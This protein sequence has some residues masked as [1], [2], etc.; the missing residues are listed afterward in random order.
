MAH[1]QDEQTYQ[2]EGLQIT[3]RVEHG[4]LFARRHVTA[5]DS[6]GFYFSEF[7]AGNVWQGHCHGQLYMPAFLARAVAEHARHVAQRDAEVQARLAEYGELVRLALPDNDVENDQRARGYRDALESVTLALVALAA[8]GATIR[9]ALEIALDA[10]GNNV[11][12]DPDADTSSTV[13]LA[14]DEVPRAA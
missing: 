10:Y 13:G 2:H 5:Q 1:W 8:P 9:G 7:V 6:E 14:R 12:E 3:V 4:G 11:Q